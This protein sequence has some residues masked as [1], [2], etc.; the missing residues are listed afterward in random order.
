MQARQNS[1]ASA[2]RLIDTATL[3]SYLSLGRHSAQEFAKKAGAER[4]F[5]KR[6]LYDKHVIDKALDELGG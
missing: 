6:L 4:R 2:A 1:D 3:C 5:G